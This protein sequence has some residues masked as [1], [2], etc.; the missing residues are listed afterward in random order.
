MVATMEP[1]EAKAPKAQQ[2][3]IPSQDEQIASLLTDV[4]TAF[5]TQKTAPKAAIVCTID[6]LL[7]H[8]EYTPIRIVLSNLVPFFKDREYT[9]IFIT[10]STEDIR[11]FLI[12]NLE[13]KEFCS[14]YFHL[15]CLPHNYCSKHQF[16][17]D[18]KLPD[19]VPSLT[20]TKTKATPT[21]SFISNSDFAEFVESIR[22]ILTDDG[23]SVAA[24]ISDIPA[25]L[26]GNHAGYAI[27]VPSPHKGSNK[28]A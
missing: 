24:T 3:T 14:E 16:L 11:D 13:D 22:R 12:A 17:V 4:T 19:F 27:S 7:W 15:I 21:Y 18:N 20:S 25:C 9:V 8:I 1:L 28:K 10:K 2:A 6:N 5:K 23:W 26:E